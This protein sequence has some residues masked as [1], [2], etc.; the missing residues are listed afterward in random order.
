MLS[1]IPV[2]TAIALYLS[3]WAIDSIDKLRRAFLWAGGDRVCGGKCKV[4]WP[5]VCRPTDLSGLGITDLRRVGIALRVRW[6][7]KDRKAGVLPR[8]KERP[9]LD[10]FRAATILNLGDGRSTF[11]WTDSWLYGSSLER[12]VPTIFA[13]VRPRKRRATVVDALAG[14]GW[15]RHLV[16]AFSLQFFVEFAD[17]CDHLEEVHLSDQPDTF[18]WGLTADGSYIVA[19]LTGVCSSAPRPLP[20]HGCCGTRRRR[21]ACDSSSGW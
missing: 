12:L 14:D 6:L 20:S 1:A 19:W 18:V 16:G 5:F 21:P 13:A 2:H 8:T 4:A 10:L 7:W 9:V 3:P 11:F 17:L 15:V